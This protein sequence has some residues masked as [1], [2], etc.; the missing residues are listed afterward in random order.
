MP[1]DPFSRA[2]CYVAARQGFVGSDLKW[3]ALETVRYCCVSTE[4]CSNLR[5]EDPSSPL[6]KLTD[7][8]TSNGGVVSESLSGNGYSPRPTVT[9]SSESEERSDETTETS[10]VPAE[11]FAGRSGRWRGLSRARCGRLA[12]RGGAGARTRDVGWGG[13]GGPGP[14]GGAGG[15]GDGGPPA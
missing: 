15:P 2:V 11:G 12:E 7:D 8:L 14:E 9:S 4:T 10:A 6:R 5:E 3:S 13:R 1:T